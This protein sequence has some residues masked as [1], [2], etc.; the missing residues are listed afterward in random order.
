MKEEEKD[1]TGIYIF[2]G[3]LPQSAEFKLNGIY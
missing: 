2:S 1:W 3:W